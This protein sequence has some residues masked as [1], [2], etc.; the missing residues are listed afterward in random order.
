MAPQLL[1]VIGSAG[2]IG[3]FLVFKNYR[4]FISLQEIPAPGEPQRYA[5][6]NR[7]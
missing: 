5:Q 1:Q 4:C 6:R 3:S 2:L 7:R